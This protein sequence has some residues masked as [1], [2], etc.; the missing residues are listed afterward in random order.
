MADF[1]GRYAL[2]RCQGSPKNYCLG[3]DFTFRRDSGQLITACAGM[4]FDGASIPRLFRG[5]YDQYSG[6]WAEAAAIHDALYI[7]RGGGQL[8]R[9]EADQVFR[10]A[11][12][13]NDVPSYR[14]WIMWAAVRIGGGPA[15]DSIEEHGEAW[16]RISR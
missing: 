12:L 2:H 4:P 10:E 16:L 1:F 7:G 3:H 6:R 13:A 14:A 11:L 9:A 5:L 15:W 8:N